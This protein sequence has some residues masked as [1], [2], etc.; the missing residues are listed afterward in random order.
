MP[1]TRLVRWSMYLGM[2]AATLSI[3]VTLGALAF[4]SIKGALAQEHAARV[5]EQDYEL[6]QRW[7]DEDVAWNDEIMEQQR[8]ILTALGTLITRVDDGEKRFRP[9]CC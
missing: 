3:I 9:T 1:E 8:D 2:V 5:A 4:G 6:N 7:Y